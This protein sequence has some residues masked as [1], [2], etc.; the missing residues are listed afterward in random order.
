MQT[1]ML[2]TPKLIWCEQEALIWRDTE[3]KQN[4][5]SSHLTTKSGQCTND[6][7]EGRNR[8]ANEKQIN[9]KIKN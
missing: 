2:E 1:E 8:K 3:Q 4:S 7:G 9:K 6:K 5:L